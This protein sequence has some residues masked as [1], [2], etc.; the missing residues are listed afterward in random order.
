MKKQHCCAVE[1]F[2]GQGHRKEMEDCLLVHR[3]GSD[4]FIVVCDGHGPKGG[5]IA[6]DIMLQFARCEKLLMSLS[7]PAFNAAASGVFC[8][9]HA[10]MSAMYSPL[11]G[12][13]VLVACVRKGGFVQIAYA[14]DVEARILVKNRWDLSRRLTALHHLTNTAEY[15]RI[16]EAT[17]GQLVIHKDHGRPCLVY[18]SGWCE[19]TRSIGTSYFDPVGHTCEPGFATAHIEPGNIL[20]IGTDGAWHSLDRRP[21]M[22]AGFEPGDVKGART[23]LEQRCSEVVPGQLASLDNYACVLGSA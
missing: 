14:G 8:K 19:L 20:M 10:D 5:D 22:F 12:A 9:I 2:S 23:F 21:L 18:G 13:A 6:K 15:T 17:S 4:M 1:A 16:S 3:S 11:S 7:G